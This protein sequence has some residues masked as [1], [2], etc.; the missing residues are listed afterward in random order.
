MPV[1]I[2]V[3]VFSGRENPIIELEGA[4]AEEVLARLKPRSRHAGTANA[5]TDLPILGYRGLIIEQ[6][7][8][9]VSGLPKSFRYARGVVEVNGTVRPA[10]DEAA[11]E[12]IFGRNG[13]AERAGLD[14]KQ[15][16]FIRDSA[17]RLPDV[18]ARLRARVGARAPQGARKYAA[19]R[20]TAC[21]GGPLFEPNWWND[22]GQ[23]QLQNNCYNYSTNY[24]TNTFAQPGRANGR[25][26][27][28]LTCAVVK[29]LAIRDNLIDS[30]NANN[31]C[32][33]AGHLVALVM[34]PGFD[35]HWYRKGQDGMWTHK[36]G[37]APA[38]ALDNGGNTITDPRQADRGPYV[39]FCGF[40]VVMH[41]HI[42]L[43]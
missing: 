38:T 43:Q 5:S 14:R 2:I 40:M 16:S 10:E 15:L 11:E 18:R 3:D 37:P 23:K 36:T 6:T 12:F 7:D 35:F 22:G 39:D 13:P 24:R 17:G 1:R 21:A 27:T 9:R 31:R 25:I 28:S 4:D 20:V 33:A 26:I 29:P 30:P 41:G 34:A 32:P 8:E 42:R 19:P